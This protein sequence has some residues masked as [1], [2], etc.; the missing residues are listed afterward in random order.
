M[1]SVGQAVGMVAGGVIG[2]FLGGNVALGASIGGMIG[3][4]LDPPKSNTQ[5][6]RLSELS[7]QVSSYGA[8]IPRLYGTMALYGCVFWIE[9]NQLKEV[10]VKKKSGGKGGGKSVTN[11]SYF[12]TFALGLCK[13]P[14]TGV[15]RIW[16]GPKL[17]YDASATDAAS[18]AA[19][20]AFAQY[21]TLY[22]GS[23]TQNPD[24]RVEANLG[25]GSTPAW[26]GLA[27]IVFKDLPLDDYGQTIAGLQVKVEVTTEAIVDSYIV[28]NKSDTTTG[29]WDGSCTINSTED[30]LTWYV[31]NFVTY[32][33]IYRTLVYNGVVQE[34]F[35]ETAFAAPLGGK[36]HFDGFAGLPYVAGG[37][38]YV[39]PGDVGVTGF[40]PVW[41]ALAINNGIRRAD[42]KTFLVRTDS[43]A[44]GA[45]YRIS[46]D[47]IVS[48]RNGEGSS[49]YNWALGDKL[50]S[51]ETFSSGPW[52][53]KTFNDDLSLAGTHVFSG[54]FIP[55]A[56]WDQH[57]PWIIGNKVYIAAIRGSGPYTMALLTLDLVALTVTEA[58]LQLPPGYTDIIDYIN[59]YGVSIS[60]FKPYP[61]GSVAVWFNCVAAPYRVVQVI[62]GPVKTFGGGVPLA[63]IV[64]AECLQSNLLTSG[65]IDVSALTATV[66][67]YKVSSAGTIRSALDPLQSVWPFDVVPSG[68]GIR[69][70]PRGTSS[71]M[72]IAESD[73]DAR[74]SGQANGVRLTETIEMDTQLPRK[75]TISY[76]D[77]SRE[78]DPSQQYS[79]RY[80]TDAV[81]ETTLELA[82]VL[83]A[84]EAAAV[85]K[86]MRNLYWTERIEQSFVIPPGPV[87]SKIEVGDVVTL[88]A[89]SGTHIV[90]ITDASY[91]P[92]GRIECKS[93][94][95]LT[96]I[97]SPTGAGESGTSTGKVVSGDAPTTAVVLDIP[98]VH[99]N[100]SGPSLLL[101]LRP[102]YGSSWQGATLVVSRDDGGSWDTVTT[103]SGPASTMGVTTA[104]LAS[105]VVYGLPDYAS[106]PV[107]MYSGEPA[108]VTL[109]KLL[110]GENLYAIG[111]PGRWEIVGVRAVTQLT[112]TTYTFGEMLRGLYGTEW[113]ATTH[114]SGDTVVLLDEDSIA[115]M[116]LNDTDLDSRLL[117]KAVSFG[118]SLDASLTVPARL[119]GVNL[120]TLSP[121]LL[122]GYRDSATGDFSISA[123]RRT[124]FNGGL[125]NYVDA[126]LNETTAA[127][128]CD[129][130]IG[131]TYEQTYYRRTLTS[132]TP[133]FAYTSADQ[134]TDFGYNPYTLYVKIYQLSE[135]RGRGTPLTG[136]LTRY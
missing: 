7:Q 106:L 64:E 90:R 45:F 2:L 17:V 38:Y 43:A 73:L 88:T 102:L 76:S 14:I 97:Y 101:A 49:I 118:G 3:G 95:H 126:P 112:A 136:E 81:N 61:D 60:A 134:V 128:E 50:F 12:G 129:I 114:Q 79:E 132:T 100:Q 62:W 46:V 8:A 63:D 9:N 53:V 48:M 1:S 120:E 99:Q 68:Y 19:T 78:Y 55:L 87:F 108:S 131:G 18:I 33:E 82:I 66:R 103:Y 130:F 115:L 89:N 125:D 111:A 28:T 80:G 27:Y 59:G 16:L 71:V 4:Y 6:P 31:N 110:N 52:T 29:N 5:G 77:F 23:S 86:Q 15:K 51:T 36:A 121:I 35:R 65:D 75:V 83:T 105:P 34:R 124:R 54:S 85:A 10:A 56:S 91:L 41:A 70:T 107:T 11:Y 57:R 116:P 93:R 113:A 109:D 24:P 94:R 104:A 13:G 21:F 42:G 20:H 72:T 26:R 25:I 96:S 123:T 58:V 30:P 67:G 40:S 122:N 119:D 74:E 117:I 32:Y 69:F 37:D 44:E 84:D 22:T 47:Q 39:L 92:D 133:T 98:Q 127:F 135:R